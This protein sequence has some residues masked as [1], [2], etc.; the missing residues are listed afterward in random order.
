MP[1]VRRNSAYLN[2]TPNASEDDH[3]GIHSKQKS[4][5]TSGET[6]CL[7]DRNMRE[8]LD[9]HQALEPDHHHLNQILRQSKEIWAEQRRRPRNLA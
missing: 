8:C 3:N 7:P 2:E 6:I 4:Y 9:R 5:A 1:N